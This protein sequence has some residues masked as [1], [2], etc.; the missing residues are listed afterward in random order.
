[1]PD[2]FDEVATEQRGSDIFDEVA[3]ETEPLR[4]QESPI[5][6]TSEERAASNWQGQQEIARMFGVSPYTGPAVSQSLMEPVVHLPR[7][8]IA[9]NELPLTAGLKELANVAIGVPETMLSPAG[10]G[11]MIAPEVGVPAFLAKTLWDVGKG[12]VEYGQRLPKMSPTEMAVGGVDL[13]AGLGMAGLLGKG[14]RQIFRRPVLPA[15]PEAPVLPE[16]P[17]PEPQ[18][19][20]GRGLPIPEAIVG[21][22][23]SRGEKPLE[24]EIP[25]SRELL[26][27][28][29]PEPV[30][31]EIERA[32]D[33][34]RAVG[35]TE[36]AKALEEPMSTA[37]VA[38]DLSA[39]IAEVEAVSP[40]EMLANK[41]AFSTEAAI[42]LGEQARTTEGAN[43]L[44]EA[45]AK[46]KQATEAALK[47][48]NLDE[49]PVL[50]H[51]NQFFNEAL[52]SAL[53]ITREKKAA[54]TRQDYDAIM[55]P[56]PEIPNAQR[57]IQT[58][59]G[60]PAVEG[61][62]VVR[63]TEGQTEAGTPLGGG[64]SPQGPRPE[65]GQSVLG[66]V[67]PQALGIV[68]PGAQALAS[69]ARAIG[70]KL[71]RVRQGFT[72]LLRSVEGRKA[73]DQGIDAADN[74]ARVVGQQEANGLRLGASEDALR[75]AFAAIEANGDPANLDRF[76]GQS[77]GKNLDATRAAE[78]AKS[79]WGDRKF[80]DLVRRASDVLDQQLA[81]EHAAGIATEEHEAYAPH[82]IDRD[83]L[84]GR[85]R[86]VIIAGG[87]GG[88]AASGFKK[89]R[90]FATIY[91]A[92]EAGY[93]PKSL[94]IASLIEHRVN[95]GQRM[96]NR[97]HWTD[98]LRGIMDPTDAKPLVTDVQY[99]T[100]GE[101]KPGY[102]VAPTG[103]TP[104]EIL[105]GVRIAVHEGY[106][107]LFDA[108]MGES[109]VAGTAPGKVALEVAGGIKH[110]LL[111]FDTFHASR[112]AQ[113][114]L[115]LTG[116]VS[117]KKGATILEY[118]DAD[119]SRAVKEGEI[120]Q[121]MADYARQNR[122]A[123]DQ[124]LR[125]GLNVGRIQEALYSS[126]I[127][128]IRGLGDFNKW[129][130]E[131]LTRGAMLESGLIEMERIAKANPGFTQEQVAMKVA[132]DLNAYF[133]NLG[134]QGIFKSATFQ[135]LARLVALAPQWVESMARTEIGGAKQ[136]IVD[137]LLKRNLA[138]GSI[139]TGVGKGLL[140]YFV[141]TQL[142]NLATR[143]TFTWQNPEPG[144]KLDA[145]IPDTGGKGNGFFISPFSVVAELTHDMIRYS[146]SEPDILAAAARI[147]S[148]K[149]SP[150]M[151]AA[152]ILLGGKDWDNSKIIGAWDK[153]KAAALA[154][155]PTPLPLS[156]LVK[157]SLFPG[158]LQRQL[159]ASA[160]FKTE[161][162]KSNVAMVHELANT[163][164]KHSAD[165]ML[166]ER[167]QREQE[168]ETGQTVLGKLRLALIRNDVEAAKQEYQTLLAAGHKAKDI[169]EQMRP[170]RADGTQKG[171]GLNAR[172]E[173]KFRNS[174]SPEQQDIYKKAIEER[175]ALWQRFLEIR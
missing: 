102:Y 40:Q 21:E 42:R 44:R 113:K 137:P 31:I 4:F 36:S 53:G 86:P 151:R 168:R 165:P 27:V 133:G 94:N 56:Q 48:E 67:E 1:M 34:A 130:F 84:V 38:P 145:W 148:N 70:Q 121:E 8:P 63:P 7:I 128:K 156:P 93:Q 136:L 110:G 144:H 85:G 153:A 37:G 57:E 58:P 28:L 127:R 22:M 95:A 2:I 172:L 119:L 152:K 173:R 167:W 101:G 99:R 17:M 169:L 155:A 118:S 3:L 12:A 15:P 109:R 5:P 160:G 33:Q 82:V 143:G 35:L 92:I 157:G 170:S 51:K 116:K 80:Q 55:R 78:Y 81:E 166:R 154:L 146:H 43:A 138:V 126:G 79:H 47:S 54:M 147:A 111:A 106:S 171:F 45:A 150:M 11:A 149:A 19:I 66:N 75:G 41:G 134:R 39:R 175:R 90:T 91:D 131:K 104:R 96:I 161:P 97:L 123:A 129:V 6:R 9:P 103:Y 26:N 73:M 23:L 72:T 124:L 142:L 112:I 89:G 162:A 158:Q 29:E 76:I 125:A 115:F 71:N 114:E 164:M 62:P 163:W 88:T 25:V 87:G 10:V 18:S 77:R 61:Q 65:P 60:L 20:S 13:A 16:V 49:L 98:G 174:L 117:Y 108:L 139:G 132:R 32:A 159:T 122:A 140:A 107:R 141:G 24:A 46:A 100:R 30:T 74:M 14:A 135:D 52:E 64:Q 83:L 50:A 68:P 120:T 69:G 105:P 59:S